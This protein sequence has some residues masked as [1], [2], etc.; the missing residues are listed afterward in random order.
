MCLIEENAF[1]ENLVNGFSRSSKQLNK[2][3]ESDSE[4]ITINENTTLAITTD[5]ICEEIETGLYEDP[6]TIGW[7][8]VTAS[9]SDLCAVGAK[10]IGLLL[11]QTF[12]RNS[13]KEFIK[14]LQRGISDACNNYKTHVLGGDTNFSDKMNMG[15]TAVG[16]IQNFKPVM[17]KGCKAGDLIYVSGK[18][19]SGNRYAFSKYSGIKQI[20][21]PAACVG[22]EQILLKYATACMDSSDGLFATLDQMIR[23]NH[24]GF[25]IS[26]SYEEY[27]EENAINLCLKQN[28]P[29]WFILAGPHGEYELVFTIESENENQFLELSKN[30][31][32]HPIKLGEV[33]AEKEVKFFN[34]QEI[35]T[36][37]TSLVR[38]LFAKSDAGLSYYINELMKIENDWRKL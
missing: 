38:N 21:K 16:L 15:A 24:L 27:L 20:Y 7:M 13:P 28:L 10:P 33:T 14:E 1:I 2:L 26:S 31:N 30:D 19:G 12:Q 3:Q 17:R 11:S 32:W 6:Y 37:D 5:S 18:V 22:K 9:I 8:M 4:L 23:V 34:N 25:K 35:Q 36:I 29:C